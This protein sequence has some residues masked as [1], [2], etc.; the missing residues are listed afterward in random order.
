MSEFDML[1]T[2]HKEREAE[3]IKKLQGPSIMIVTGGKGTLKVEGKEHEVKEGYVF[4]IGY[5]TEIKLVMGSGL[6][7]HIAFAEARTQ[8]HRMI[9]NDI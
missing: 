9:Q 8:A 5:N 3:T 7:I 1:V 2:N 6:E 4:F